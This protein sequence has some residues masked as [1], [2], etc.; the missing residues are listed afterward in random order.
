M[1]VSMCDGSC[2]SIVVVMVT[3]L[4]VKEEKEEEAKERKRK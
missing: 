1:R 3:E 2:G 4:C